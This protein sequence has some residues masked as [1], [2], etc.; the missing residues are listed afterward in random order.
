[1]DLKYFDD[2][3]SKKSENYTEEEFRESNKM[4]Q[5]NDLKEYF[6]L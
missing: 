1:M 6:D 3:N 4:Q 5:Q 2:G